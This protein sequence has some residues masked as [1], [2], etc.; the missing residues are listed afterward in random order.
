VTAQTPL[1]FLAHGGDD[2]SVPVENSILYY[3]ALLKAGVP[4][5]LHVYQHAPHGFGL[6]PVDGPAD[7][8]PKHCEEWMRF[9]GLIK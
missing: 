9:N 3:N 1:T 5:E 8:W 2:R 7:Q 6:R 4:A